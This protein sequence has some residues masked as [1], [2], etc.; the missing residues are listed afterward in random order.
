MNEDMA[1]FAT[2]VEQRENHPYP[3]LDKIGALLGATPLCAQPTIQER[4]EP[5][6]TEYDRLVAQLPWFEDGPP[7]EEWYTPTPKLVALWDKI[8]AVK[9]KAFRTVPNPVYAEACAEAWERDR[10]KPYG[11]IDIKV[12]QSY[13]PMSTA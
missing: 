1:R 2:W 5:F 6:A 9:P 7:D 3:D 8:D 13:N 4:V 11:Q 10:R 12:G